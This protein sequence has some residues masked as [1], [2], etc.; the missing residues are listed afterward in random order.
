MA[1]CMVSW[2]ICM[3]NSIMSQSSSCTHFFFLPANQLIHLHVVQRTIHSIIYIYITLSDSSVLALKVDINV[4]LPFYIH[5]RQFSP[6]EPCTQGWQVEQQHIPSC[7]SVMMAPH[8]STHSLDLFYQ[9]FSPRL[10]LLYH[11]EC[12]YN[13]MRGFF[14]YTKIIFLELLI[15]HFHAECK[16]LNLVKFFWKSAPRTN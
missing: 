5:M 14:F 2:G 7:R 9:I 6:C 8:C 3:Q 13:P 15:W 12:L 11:P 16:C 1:I 4:Y 10:V